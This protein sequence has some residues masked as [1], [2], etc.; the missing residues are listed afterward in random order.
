VGAKELQFL[1]ALQIEKKSAILTTVVACLEPV[2][3][4]Q[5]NVVLLFTD[6]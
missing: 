4:C 1:S 2:G 3:L 5:R 6:L